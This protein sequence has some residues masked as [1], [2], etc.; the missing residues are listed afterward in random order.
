MEREAGRPV[1]AKKE[2]PFLWLSKT[3]Y[4]SNESMINDGSG[5]WGFNKTEEQA[6]GSELIQG[7]FT[8]ARDWDKR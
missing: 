1:T 3:I 2:K 8:R 5:R 6:W 4:T 7:A